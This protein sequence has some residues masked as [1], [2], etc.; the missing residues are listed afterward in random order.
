M[1]EI[2]DNLSALLGEGDQ[3]TLSTGQT[4]TIKPVTFRKLK[5]MCGFINLIQQ[6]FPNL[7]AIDNETFFAF[8]LNHTEDLGGLVAV[9]ADR[10]PAE[11]EDLPLSDF[12]KVAMGVIRVNAGFFERELNPLIRLLKKKVDEY[13]KSRS[14]GLN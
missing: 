11:I 14:T 4:I 9:L 1:A 10:E 6:A 2:T 5:P 13:L 12:F 7:E 8:L 3:V